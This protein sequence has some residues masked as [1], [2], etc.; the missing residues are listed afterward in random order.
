MYSPSLFEERVALVTG[1]GRGIGRAVAHQL[2]E[3]GADV[4][5]ND[6]SAESARATARTIESE[7]GSRATATPADVSDPDEVT[8]MVDEASDTLGPVQ[9]LVNNAATKNY[10]PL[11]ELTVEDWERVIRVNLTAPFLV[12]REVARRLL[13]GGQTGSVVNIASISALRPQPGSGGYS[14][15]KKALVSLTEQ[16]AME[17]GSEGIPV[18]SIC[19]GMIWTEAGEAVYSDDELREQRESFVPMAKIGRPEH[20]ANA[21]V[22]ML[23]PENGYLNGESLVLDGGLQ[24]IGNDRLAGKTERE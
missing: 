20:V 6:I 18:N 7:T 17:W 22:Y 24:L 21:A 12:A 9:H 13:D 11:V 4:A 3:L 5:V 2:A 1:A 10:A 8:A 15:S 23:A 14:P 16:M 19:P